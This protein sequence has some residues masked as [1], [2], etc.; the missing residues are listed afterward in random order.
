MYYDGRI[1]CI[2]S[3]DFEQY[4][5]TYIYV[6][7]HIYIMMWKSS[8]DIAIAIGA[9]TVDITTYYI[10]KPVLSLQTKQNK[11]YIIWAIIRI[12]SKTIIGNIE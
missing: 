1:Q 7:T 3:K 4:D 9:Y 2:H 12:L 8:T 10:M 5:F 6:H 11:N